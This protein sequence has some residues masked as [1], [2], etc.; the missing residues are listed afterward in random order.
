MGELILVQK[1]C[2]TSESPL[3][4]VASLPASTTPPPPPSVPSTSTKTISV[5]S[6]SPP[7]PLSGS[8]RSAPSPRESLVAFPRPPMLNS[9]RP[10]TTP[11]MLSRPGRWSLSPTESELCLSSTFICK[12]SKRTPYTTEVIA[13]MLAASGVPDG[14]VNIVQGGKPTV[15]N[16]C[17]HED[18]RAV[19]FVGANTAGEYIY[20]R[21]SATG[22]RAQVNMGAKNHCIVLADADRED[23]VNIER[24]IA[25]GEKNA[26]LLLDGRNPV[27]EGYP[28]G[29]WIGPTIIDGCDQGMACYD[30]EIFGPVMCI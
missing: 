16:I 3:P 23:T 27:V 8:T 18:I 28:H 20:T 1:L 12:P 19:S 5:E 14:V 4:S 17:D 15:D 26:S 24:L 21:A 7:P 30:E 13:D 22:K 10:S 9:T 11:P 25:D 2:L 6:G 29:N